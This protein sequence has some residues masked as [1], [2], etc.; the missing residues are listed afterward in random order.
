MILSTK[1]RKLVLNLSEPARV[2]MSIPTA[3]TFV[4]KNRELVAVPHKMEETQVLRN[5]GYKVPSPVEMYY[6]WSGQYTPFKAQLETAA[7]LTLNNRAFVLNGMG[8]GKTLSALWAFDYLRSIGIAKKLL[9]VSPL[10]TLERTW[11]DEIFRHFPHLTWATLYGSREKRQRVLNSEAD[12]YLI[13]H[14]GIKVMEKE[15]QARTDIDVIVVD[16]IASFRNAGTDRW[17]ALH[18]IVQSRK[19]VWG[20]TG[21]PTPNA[22]TDAWAQCRLISPERVPKY[23]N[24][25][26]D[27]TMK[28][29]S[30][31]KWIP[32]DNATEVVAAAM[33]PSIRFAREDCI[34]LPPCMFQTRQVEMSVP[35][36]KAY[37][38]M[39]TQLYVE[40][41]SGEVHAVNEAVKLQKL[42]QIASGVVYAKD[43]TH[44][45]IQAHDRIQE[46]LDIIEQAGTKVIIFAP[47]KGS[48]EY[49]EK[50]I[51][52]H[53]TCAVISGEVAKGARDKIFHDF[54]TGREPHVL[55]AQPA[56]MAHG[57]TLTAASTIIWFAPITSQEIYTQANARITRP[58]QK[59]SQLI[60]NI[61]GSPVERRLYDR[62][63]QKQAAEGLLLDIIRDQE[64]C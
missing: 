30:Q 22:P 43:G 59:H 34:D 32:R 2:L 36:K 5:L 9:V 17:K 39:L 62:L 23:F 44:V 46:C 64:D 54:Q 21:T 12:I 50:E 33:Q 7:F 37:R 58:G 8:S 1:H 40:L 11:A 25:F 51:S 14:D 45:E 24:Q 56:A 15:L 41:Q 6:D 57:L 47:F 63:R 52:K 27:M 28:Q 42:V 60:V 35:Q 16:E 10:S 20:L 38:E 49:I 31:F 26:R 53:H 48:L 4:Y 61:E 55:V 29:L 13:N 19:R 18:R 3:K